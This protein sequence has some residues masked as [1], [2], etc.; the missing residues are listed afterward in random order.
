MTSLAGTGIAAVLPM[1]AYG[2]W[3]LM[4]KA[5]P[6][7]LPEIP[8]PYYSEVLGEMTQL[9]MMPVGGPR[10]TP[11]G[12]DFPGFHLAPISSG[13]RDPLPPVPTPPGGWPDPVEPEAPPPPAGG[14]TV[15]MISTAFG[16]LTDF[17]GGLVD[18]GG[19]I[20]QGLGYQSIPSAV[21]G[22]W[23]TESQAAPRPRPTVGGYE[24]PEGVTPYNPEAAV[25]RYV[26]T[27][28][29]GGAP[30]A[31]QALGF[32]GFD[33]AP[34]GSFPITP[35]ETGGAMRLPSR[36]D[37][38]KQTRGGV[39]YVTYRNMGRPLLFQ[40][41]LAACKRVKRVASKAKRAKGR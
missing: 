33:V 31:Q 13:S 41:D 23:P 34:S 35:Y 17:I 12:K 3:H 7:D 19:D 15:G 2:F 29:P 39:R 5:D 1:L 40:G 37:V 21:M 22:L 27:A 11:F 30:L 28:L 26:P 10:S 16:G 9:R 6:F 18:F 38:P 8:R 25:M 36:I 4:T 20:A 32:P 24:Y 14:K